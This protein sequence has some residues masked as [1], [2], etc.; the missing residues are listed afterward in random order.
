MP[1]GKPESGLFCIFFNFPLKFRSP[2]ADT[3]VIRRIAPTPFPQHQAGIVAAR[4]DLWAKQR[5]VTMSI[6]IGSKSLTNM[7]SLRNSS[8]SRAEE[9]KSFEKLSSGKRINRAAD[10]AAGLAIAEQMGAILK[11]LE[12]GQEN[13]YDGLSMV[14]TADAAL[15]STTDQLHR[16]R[17]LAVAAGSDVLNPQQRNAI[18]IEFDSVYGQIDRTAASTEF[19]GQKMLDGSAGEVEISLGQDAGTISLDFSQNMDAASLGLDTVQLSGADGSNARSALADI[20]QA[21]EAISTQR[22]EFGSTSNRLMSANQGL[23]VAAENTYASRS[24]I[25]D[26]D[27]AKQ[28]AELTR[29]QILSQASTAVTI[30]GRLIPSSVLSLLE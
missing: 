23:A 30:Q 13:V 12:Q 7:S 28:T 9:Q 2:P 27:Y 26:T 25:I 4:R 21:L 6:R 16:M 20:D 19:N 18:Q 1:A 5:I 3:H 8:R 22:A 29:Q 15:G 17:E 14:D 24:R 10:D 11:S